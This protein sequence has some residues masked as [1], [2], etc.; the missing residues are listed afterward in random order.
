MSEFEHTK[1][2]LVSA[3]SAPSLPR[4]LVGRRILSLLSIGM[5]YVS[6][7]GPTTIKKKERYL[8]L[9]LNLV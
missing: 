6:I 7:F 4:R 5:M 9:D 8:I 3:S 1:V 2:W